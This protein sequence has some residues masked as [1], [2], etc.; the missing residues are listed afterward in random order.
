MAWRIAVSL[1]N[2]V[3]VQIVMLLF[4]RIDVRINEREVK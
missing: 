4:V 2:I 3:R 1:N